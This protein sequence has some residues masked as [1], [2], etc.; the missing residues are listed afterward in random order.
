MEVFELLF[1]GVEEPINA[2]ETMG[3]DTI[4]IERRIFGGTEKHSFLNKGNKTQVSGK[5]V[6]PW[7][8][9]LDSQSTVNFVMN[10]KPV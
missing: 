6:I 5:A 3:A 4:D 1:L 2:S 9:L 8:L 10:K 7:W